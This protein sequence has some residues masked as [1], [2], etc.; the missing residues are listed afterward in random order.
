MHR[1]QPLP[2]LWLITDER[3]GEELWA[4]LQRLPRGS[5]IVFRHYGL[6]PAARETMFLK[7]QGVARRRRLL[8]RK[9]SW[10]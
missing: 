8:V 9:A 3:Q 6:S 10:A 2:R 5:G 7:V 1:R 4:A